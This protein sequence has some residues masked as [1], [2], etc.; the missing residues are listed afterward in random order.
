M[1]VSEI[2]QFA[3]PS[4]TNQQLADLALTEWQASRRAA[5]RGDLVSCMTHRKECHALLDQ[6]NGGSIIATPFI[7]EVSHNKV[8]VTK[9]GMRLFNMRWP[10]SRLS[11]ERA[12]W[13]EFDADGDLIDHDVPEHSDGSESAALAEDCKA[14]LFDDDLPEWH[15]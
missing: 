1:P 14:W 4:L 6:I 2:T 8:R 3:K 13:F 9:E 12:Y 11:G 5:K 7:H 15:P 10:C